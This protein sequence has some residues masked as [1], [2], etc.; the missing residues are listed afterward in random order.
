MQ[1]DDDVLNH[2]NKVKVFADQF[3]FLEVYVQEKY[4]IMIM[5][6][7]LPVSYKYF[8]MP[9]KELMME[10]VTSCLM[11]EMSKC[12]KK[13]PQSEDAAMMSCKSKAF[14]TP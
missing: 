13:E 10:Y 3:P 11:Y 7:N 8:M 9:M 6:E 4:I 2:N 12:K 1:E 5:F 14:N